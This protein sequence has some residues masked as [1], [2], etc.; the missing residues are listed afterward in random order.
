MTTT[1]TD[2][3]T[4]RA[5]EPVAPVDIDEAVPLVFDYTDMAPGDSISGTP[6]VTCEVSAGVDA[7]PASRRSGAPTVNGLQVV[8]LMDNCQAG[9]TYLVRCKAVMSSGV[10]LVQAILLPCIKVG[11]E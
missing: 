8:Q 9:A 10:T 11:A 5:A 6:V 4:L 3:H 2:P 1:T 7:D